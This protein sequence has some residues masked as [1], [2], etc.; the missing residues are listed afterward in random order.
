[1]IEFISI[2]FYTFYLIH[3]VVSNA[4]LSHNHMEFQNTADYIVCNSPT[5]S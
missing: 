2:Y 5:C 4:L 1:M 3:H